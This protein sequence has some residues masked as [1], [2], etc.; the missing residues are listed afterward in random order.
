MGK[1]QIALKKQSKNQQMSIE[2]GLLK[3]QG[4]SF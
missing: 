2:L 4:F 1:M 3:S